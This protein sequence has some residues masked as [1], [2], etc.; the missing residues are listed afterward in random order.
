MSGGGMLGAT[1]GITGGTGSFGRTMVQHLLGRGVG[2]INILSRDEAKQDDMRRRFGDSRLHFF[3]GDIRDYDS[4]AAAFVDTDFVFHAAA[5][6]QVPSCEFFPAQAVK[7]NVIGSSNVVEAA[8][9]KGVR[10]VV[11]LQHRQ[12]GVPG[13]RDG[14]VQ[15]AHGEDRAGLRT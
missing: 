6:K 5:L 10:S 4:V 14:H 3:L 13:Q 9:A 7:T 15:G 2:A 1:V 11:L 8:A 12:G